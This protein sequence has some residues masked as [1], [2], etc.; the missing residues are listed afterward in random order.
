MANAGLHMVALA[1]GPKAR[2]Q[3]VRGERLADRAD[4]V[5]LAFDRQQHGL[6]DRLRIDLAALVF[7]FAQRQRMILE[8]EAVKPLF[9]AASYTPV[10]FG[11]PIPACHFKYGETTY[12]NGSWTVKIWWGAAGEIAP[13]STVRSRGA[14]VFGARRRFAKTAA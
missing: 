1:I 2:A 11:K 7:E 12:K 6:L 14:A 5:A 9:D 3:I 4:V 8:Y 10:G 13:G